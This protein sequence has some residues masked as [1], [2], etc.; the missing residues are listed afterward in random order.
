VAKGFPAPGR[1]LPLI[2][3]GLT[4][5]CSPLWAGTLQTRFSTVTVHNLPIGYWTK[6]ELKGGESYAVENTSRQKVKVTLKST[7]PFER[8]AIGRGYLMIP[9]PGWITVEPCELELEP[10]STGYAEVRLTIPDDPKYAGKRFEGWLMATGV[11]PQ[12]QAGLI[13]RIRFNTVAEPPRKPDEGRSFEAATDTPPNKEHDSG[14]R[15]D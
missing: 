12:F 10:H 11:G 3:L 7:R 2:L 1:R 8:K 15:P 6:V 4:C 13:T 9:D 14:E 5:L